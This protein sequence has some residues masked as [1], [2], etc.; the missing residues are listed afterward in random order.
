MRL[1]RKILK[2]RKTIF[3]RGSIKFAKPKTEV[4]NKVENVKKNRIRKMNTNRNNVSVSTLIAYMKVCNNYN[5]TGS[6]T[7]VCKKVKV[8]YIES[9]GMPD[10]LDMPNFHEPYGKYGCMLCVYNVMNAYFKLMSAS[11]ST[12]TRMSVNTEHIKAKTIVSPKVRKE[13][14]VSKP[15]DIPI[16][17]NTEKVSVNVK[18]TA[19]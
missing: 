15:K 10:M 17:A 8:E 11:A 5:S 2:R 9:S 1:L 7:F 6:L 13:T 3:L 19:C 16:K 12:D 18:D 4:G 14:P